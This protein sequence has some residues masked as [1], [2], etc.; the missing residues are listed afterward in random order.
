MPN[1]KEYN[2]TAHLNLSGARGG[3]LVF[4]HLLML[5]RGVTKLTITKADWATIEASVDRYELTT[6][7]D[8]NDTSTYYLRERDSAYNKSR[9]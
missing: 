7:T 9:N 1:S 4:A 5:Q 2:A 8:P 6:T 3:L